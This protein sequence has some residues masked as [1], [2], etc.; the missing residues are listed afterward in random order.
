MRRCRINDKYRAGKRGMARVGMA[1]VITGESRDKTCWWMTLHGM[2]SK[3][4]MHKSF[5]NEE[6]EDEQ[7]SG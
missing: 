4:C 1:G 5:V 6:K 7:K 3:I 2:R